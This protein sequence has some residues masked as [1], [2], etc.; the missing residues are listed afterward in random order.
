MIISEN[1]KRRFVKDNSLPIKIFDSPVFENRLAMFET[2]FKAKSKYD[3]FVK[4]LE[5]NFPDEGAYFDEHHRVA[6]AALAYMQENEHFQYF[7]QKEDMK[8]FDVD[9]QGLPGNS[10]FK[11]TNVG[12]YLLSID[13][14]KANFTAMRFY[15]PEIFGGAETYE[16]FIGMFTNLEHIKKSKYI[17]QMIFGNIVPKRQQ[18]YEKFLMNKVLEGFFKYTPFCKKNVEYFGTDEIVFDITEFVIDGKLTPGI[19]LVVYELVDRFCE[20]GI[21]IRCEYYHLKKVYGTSGYMKEYVFGTADKGVE[22]KCLE[23]LEYPFVIRAYEG[24]AYT[25][26]EYYFTYE[27]RLA[28]LMQPIEVSFSDVLKEEVEE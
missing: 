25:G 12:K 27:G 10:V 22:F 21:N 1:L 16:D 20:R 18:K 26:D 11:D 13:M 23:P 7:S 24:S 19:D 17:R 28:K 9:Q 14:V 2:Q 6:D 8:Q 4:M 3:A 5:E 15:N